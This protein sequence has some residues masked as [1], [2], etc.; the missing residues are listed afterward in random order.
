MSDMTN[1][2]DLVRRETSQ[3]RTMKTA[4]RD[5][6]TASENRNDGSRESRQE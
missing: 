3:H 5:S 1:L 2:E 4:S 6:H